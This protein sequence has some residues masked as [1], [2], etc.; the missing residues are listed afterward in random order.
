[1][2]QIIP[3]LTGLFKVFQGRKREECSFCSLANVDPSSNM[4]LTSCISL[5]YIKVLTAEI[6]SE[7]PEFRNMPECV[8]FLIVAA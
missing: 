6:K 3:T 7:I 4:G 2:V 1:M 8:I 5:K